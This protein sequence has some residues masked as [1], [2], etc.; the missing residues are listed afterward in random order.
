[1]TTKTAASRAAWHQPTSTAEA[2][3]RSRE[4]R[5]Y[6]AARRFRAD[7][8]AIEIFRRLC[9]LDFVRGSQS[10]VAEDLGVSAATVSRAVARLPMPPDELK[11]P[12]C[13]AVSLGESVHIRADDP[14]RA[15]TSG[16]SKRERMNSR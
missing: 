14:V 2:F 10:R 15:T 4:R 13:G 16:S 11:C 1:M 9:A 5:A 8:L 6:N 12:V 3:R 7:Q